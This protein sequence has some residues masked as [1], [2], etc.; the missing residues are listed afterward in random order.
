VNV[1]PHE[2]FR[3]LINEPTVV[4][5]N[6]VQLIMNDLRTGRWSDPDTAINE[7]G[8]AHFRSPALLAKDL[9]RCLQDHPKKLI[10]DY[11]SL[12]KC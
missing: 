1:Q 5:S 4:Y 12:K 2:Y 11:Q 10:N 6:V 9:R 7:P 3:L 8:I